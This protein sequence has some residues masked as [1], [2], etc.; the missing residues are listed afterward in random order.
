M[1]RTDVSE[2]IATLTIDRLEVKN[3]LDLETV[4]QIRDALRR[5]EAD[6]SVVLHV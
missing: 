2:P 1:V 6:A 5:F 3:A 4:N